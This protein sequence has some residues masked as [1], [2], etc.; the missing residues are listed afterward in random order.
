M[1]TWIAQKKLQSFTVF[2]L[3]PLKLKNILRLIKTHAE[4]RLKALE[5]ILIM[6]PRKLKLYLS[7][8]P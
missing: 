2:L 4:E 6:K 7:Y 3:W 5:R 8:F 1:A